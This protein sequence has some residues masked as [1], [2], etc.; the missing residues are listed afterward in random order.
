MRKLNDFKDRLEI[1]GGDPQAWPVDDRAAAE[2][3]L[4]AGDENANAAQALLAE[5]QKLDAMLNSWDAPAPESTN[6][7]ERI[8]ATATAQ[9]QNGTQAGAKAGLIET[10]G[11]LFG[12][13]AAVIMTGK[14]L[15]VYPPVTQ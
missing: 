15:F 2:A 4:N 10:I 14:R 5:T 11:D 9:P 7:A 6:L 13:N 8:I 12:I 1:Y 3:L